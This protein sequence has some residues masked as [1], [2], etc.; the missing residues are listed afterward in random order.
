MLRWDLFCRVVD[1]FGDIGICWRL[2]RQLAEEHQAVVRL[3]VDD[4]HC[5]S[6]LCPSISV[7]ARSQRLNQIEVCHWQPQYVTGFTTKDVGDVVIE[8]FACEIPEVYVMAMAARVSPPV[9]INLEYLSAEDWVE[10]CHLLSSPHPKL[11]IR[12]H[13]FFP[14]FTARTGGLIREQSLIKQRIAFDDAQQQKFFSALGI[15]DRPS[16]GTRISLFC[17]SNPALPALL[18]CWAGGTAPIQLLVTSGAACRQVAEWLGEPLD[19]GQPCC[20]GPLSVHAIPFLPQSDYDRVLWGCD[21]NFVRGED[22]F[23]RAQWAGR[24][25]VWQIYPQTDDVHLTKLNAFL[26]RYVAGFEEIAS[27][28]K[29]TADALCGFWLAWNGRGEVASAW[30]SFAAALHSLEQSSK[31]WALQLDRMSDLANNLARFVHGN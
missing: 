16:L 27:D 10:S 6:A 14:G 22:S 15:P 8:A 13:F 5:F 30:N 3:W 2:A 23:V 24:P 20:R 29:A 28:R 17:Y 18:D 1:N 19:L 4:L 11:P 12:K 26:M 9:W 21:L 25:F 7:T 31:D